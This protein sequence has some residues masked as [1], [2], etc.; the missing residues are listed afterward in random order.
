MAHAP[1]HSS[2]TIASLPSDP[3]VAHRM[4]TLGWRRGGQVQVVKKAAGG[5]KVIDLGGSRIAVS[6]A[7]ART[8]LVEALR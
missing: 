2:F 4:M 5:A 7:L 8:L 1:L 6:G 3:Q